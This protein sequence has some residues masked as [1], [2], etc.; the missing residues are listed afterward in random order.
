MDLLTIFGTSSGFVTA[1]VV[2][3]YLLAI[4]TGLWALFEVRTPQGTAAWIVF[5]LSFPL[6]ALPA[7]WIFGRKK[8]VGYKSPRLRV[9]QATQAIQGA[10]GERLASSGIAMDP[11][12]S[13]F[14]QAISKL[15]RVPFT[16]HNHAELLVDGQ[17]KFKRLFEALEQAREYILVQY[18]IVRA[19]TVGQQL[20]SVLE[21]KAR[22]GL[23]VHF[24][25]DDVGTSLPRDYIAGLQ[26][27]GVV[28]DSFNTTNSRRRKR[29]QINFRN[30]RKTV[31]I[32]GRVGFVGGLNVGDEYLGHHQ[33]LK[34]WR[35]THLRLEGPVV[36]GLQL[37]FQEDWY[38]ARQETLK[39]DWE[40]SPSDE[41]DMTALA[42]PSG[43]A[44]PFE[45]ATLLHMSAVQ[46]ARERLWIATPYFVPDEQFIS[47]LQLSA[48]RGV[49]VR[50]IVPARNDG[51]WN[52]MATVALMK[53]LQQAGVKFYWFGK[54]F[55]HQKVLLVDRHLAFVGTANFD[56]RSFRLNFEMTVAV[57]DE[58]FN[59][60][61]A[62]MLEN[63]LASSKPASKDE[64]ARRSFG[65]RAAAHAI[66][67]LAPI[68]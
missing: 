9:T 4:A 60:Q 65:Y 21:A 39:L 53:P 42:V 25:Y 11:V 58:S 10:I 44:D 7:F 49:D 50:V 3:V 16:N 29:L 26:A 12:K 1:F 45:T 27:A 66:R 19:D 64:M 37:F 8:F 68:L 31:V 2:L 15:I 18:Y 24:L 67:L 55:M 33:V 23:R 48:L 51:F 62:A 57:I 41:S 20:R 47:A 35:D 34:P 14:T 61:V 54:G 28:V 46:E 63:D 52:K 32:D 30:H 6:F 56:C 43:P 40:P 36:L 59:A 38:W 17:Q 13:P 5:L 22:A